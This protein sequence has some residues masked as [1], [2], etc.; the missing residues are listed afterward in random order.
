[1]KLLIFLFALLPSLSSAYEV[2]VS[3]KEVEFSKRVSISNPEERPLIISLSSLKNPGLS[4]LP[5][6]HESDDRSGGSTK[7]ESWVDH[8]SVTVDWSVE[9]GEDLKDVLDRWL[10]MAGYTLVY[11]IGEPLPIE[12]SYSYKSKS[13][14]EAME[15]FIGHLEKNPPD[16]IHRRYKGAIHPNNYFVFEM[17]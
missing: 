2:V 6:Q 12:G 8:Q 9:T 15:S 16:S 7:K 1:M 4:Q 3:D 5:K 14:F 17:I 11:K 13:V 10:T